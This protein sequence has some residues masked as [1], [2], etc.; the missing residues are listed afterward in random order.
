MERKYQLI[1]KQQPN[2]NDRNLTN[3]LITTTTQPPISQSFVSLVAANKTFYCVMCCKDLIALNNLNNSSYS[4]SLSG[5]SINHHQSSLSNQAHI[6][7][8]LMTE[9]DTSGNVIQK[10]LLV[11]SAQEINLTPFLSSSSSS[12]LNTTCSTNSLKQLQLLHENDRVLLCYSCFSSINNSSTSTTTTPSSLNHNNNCNSS[13]SGIYSL[14]Q[15]QQQQ[16][17]TSKATTNRSSTH[18]SLND[19]LNG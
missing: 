3:Q 6:A 9:N 4:S 1:R 11:Q 19:S 17:H 5:S 8:S 14:E 7:F 2:L 13:S 16:Q 18:H 15:P 10:K 12:T